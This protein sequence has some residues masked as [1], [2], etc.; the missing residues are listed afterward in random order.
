M[1]GNVVDSPSGNWMR[2]QERLTRIC[3]EH[4]DL[5]VIGTTEPI[6]LVWDDPPVIRTTHIS[7]WKTIVKHTTDNTIIYADYTFSRQRARKRLIKMLSTYAEQ[8]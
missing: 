2:K 7:I 8:Q 6:V 4:H 3:Y 1:S 5:D